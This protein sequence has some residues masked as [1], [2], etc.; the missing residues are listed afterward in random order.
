[1]V[2]HPCARLAGKTAEETRERMS[3]T[4]NRKLVEWVNE[5]AALCT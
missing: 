3:M 5:I 2:P 1:M 4:N